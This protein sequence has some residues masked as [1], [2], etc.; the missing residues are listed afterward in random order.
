MTL[1]QRLIYGLVMAAVVFFVGQIV[2]SV[3]TLLIN[4]VFALAMGVFAIFL[5][6][7]AAKFSKRGK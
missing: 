1:Q 6:T 7:L 2:L 3:G 5:V 4:I